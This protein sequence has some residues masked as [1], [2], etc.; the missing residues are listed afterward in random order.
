M[1]YV[2]ALLQG[3]AGLREKEACYVRDQDITPE[4][5][6]ISITGTLAH[7]PNTRPS[8][9]TMPV[10]PARSKALTA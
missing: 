4:T 5:G 2:W 7:K 9:R 8:Y 1:F 10:S 6:V 3:C